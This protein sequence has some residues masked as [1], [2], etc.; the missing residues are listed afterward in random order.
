MPHAD[1][2]RSSIQR[3]PFSLYLPYRDLMS[4][5]ENERFWLDCG[6]WGR[7]GEERRENERS[8]FVDTLRDT[9]APAIVPLLALLL[10][11]SS[12]VT[13]FFQEKSD[14]E[15][16]GDRRCICHPTVGCIIIWARRLPAKDIF[17]SPSHINCTTSPPPKIIQK[18]VFFHGF[19]LRW[20]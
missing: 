5:G 14:D 16:I 15:A 7:W 6:R 8:H 1:S 9:H 2:E 13:T 18:F 10:A 11:T 17:S 19:V 20:R 3:R 12:S 4:D